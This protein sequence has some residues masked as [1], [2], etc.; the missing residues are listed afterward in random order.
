M[1]WWMLSGIAS[2]IL[3][4]LLWCAGSLL[5]L[6]RRYHSFSGLDQ[7]FSEL[8]KEHRIPQSDS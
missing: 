6:K 8:Q 3:L 7:H 1:L 5:Y 4:M 2:F